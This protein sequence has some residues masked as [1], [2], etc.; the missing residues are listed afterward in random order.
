MV[1]CLPNKSKAL[2]SNPVQPNKQSKTEQMVVDVVGNC[3][4]KFP[5]IMK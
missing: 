5:E 4:G 2:S 1:E 3:L